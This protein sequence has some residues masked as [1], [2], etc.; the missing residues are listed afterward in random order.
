MDG[1]RKRDILKQDFR[2]V[3]IGTVGEGTLECALA[4]AGEG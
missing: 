3:L 2:I 1:K 4:F